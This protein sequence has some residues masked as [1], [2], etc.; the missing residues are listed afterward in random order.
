MIVKLLVMLTSRLLLGAPLFNLIHDHGT[1]LIHDL[2]YPRIAYAQKPGI[3][4]LTDC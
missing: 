2:R 4:V 1:P 3:A